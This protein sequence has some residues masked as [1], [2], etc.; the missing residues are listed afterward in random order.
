MNEICN[1]IPVEYWNHCCGK[2]NPASREL[3]PLELSVNQMW[4]NGPGWLKKLIN[5][6]PALALPDE[7]PD[8]SVAELKSNNQGVVHNLLTTQPVNRIG[9]LIDIERFSTTQ[10]LYQTTAC[11]LKFVWFLRKKV[12]S[13]ELTLCDLSEA[14]RLWIMDTQSSMVQDQ[15]FPRWKVQFGLFQHDYQIWRCGGRLHNANLAYS[16]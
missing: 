12:T 11:V 16:S 10:R 9:Q 3:T 7:I 14:A 4:K 2:E 8:L 5:V 15:I 13:A 6:V 1:L